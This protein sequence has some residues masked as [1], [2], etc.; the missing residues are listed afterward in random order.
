LKIGKKFE[1]L[2]IGTKFEIGTNF[3]KLDFSKI[4][5]KF[6]KLEQN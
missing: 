2:K 4:G 5:T 1:N 3:E 6:Q